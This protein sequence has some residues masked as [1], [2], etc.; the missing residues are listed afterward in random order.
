MKKKTLVKKY[1][2]LFFIA[3]E[4]FKKDIEIGRYMVKNARYKTSITV[5]YWNGSRNQRKRD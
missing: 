4:N 2:F 3:R 1:A 5:T